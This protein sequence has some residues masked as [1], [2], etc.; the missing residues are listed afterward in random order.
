MIDI[1]RIE[2]F[3]SCLSSLGF[4]LNFEKGSN[5]EKYSL[6]GYIPSIFAHHDIKIIDR[7]LFIRLS[8]CLNSTYDKETLIRGFSYSCF[9]LVGNRLYPSC[10]FSEL[11][12]DL[13]HGYL[14]H[15]LYSREQVEN[16]HIAEF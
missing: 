9:S 11:F 8:P 4:E 7:G 2:L 12:L 16:Y 5:F 10:Y 1:K 3:S 13:Q 15:Q 6:R 14:Y